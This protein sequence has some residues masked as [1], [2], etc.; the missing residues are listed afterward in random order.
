MKHDYDWPKIWALI[1]SGRTAYQVSK[2]PN[3]PSREGI[4]KALKRRTQNDNQSGRAVAKRQPKSLRVC[5]PENK[6]RV[7]DM[8]AT[9]ATLKLA[10]TAA[11]ISERT[12]YN[13]RQNDADFA[14][15]LQMAK[16]AFLLD[17][18]ANI[19][20]ASKRDWKAGAY[21]LER[22]PES[23]DEFGRT[24]ASDKPVQVILNII[25]GD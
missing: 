24:D 23:R 11:G 5:N 12:L 9:G 15:N 19:A 3:M 21:L 16:G 8:A 6:Q 25:R 20:D 1:D 7:V 18:V 14:A 13:W 10:A 2:L 17:M 4:R 22:A